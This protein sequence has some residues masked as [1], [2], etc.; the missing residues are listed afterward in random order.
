MFSLSDCLAEGQGRGPLSPTAAT[1]GA[2]WGDGG[3]EG[4]PGSLPRPMATSSGLRRGR[5]LRPSEVARMKRRA[6]LVALSGVMMPWRLPAHPPLSHIHAHTDTGPTQSRVHVYMPTHCT[7]TRDGDADAH[8]HAPQTHAYT[9]TSTPLRARV[10]G[11]SLISHAC[12]DSHVLTVTCARTDT[13]REKHAGRHVHLDTQTQ[14]H[15]E[16]GRR[17]TRRGRAPFAKTRSTPAHLHARPQADTR[18]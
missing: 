10:R 11:H 4:E 7:L 18:R 16:Q 2:G 8:T 14:E 9:E 17:H 13:A 5:V 6:V 12:G 1:T 3:E 15:R